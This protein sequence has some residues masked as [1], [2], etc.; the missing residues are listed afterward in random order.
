MSRLEQ[1]TRA[2]YQVN[3]QWECEFDDAEKPQLLTHP[4]VR[5]SP[6]CTHDFL[7]GGRTEA[8]RLHYKLQ[9]NETIQYVDV[10]SV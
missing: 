9:Q 1:I 2:E 4:I 3:V 5:Q 6:L 8:M 7:Y 10:M